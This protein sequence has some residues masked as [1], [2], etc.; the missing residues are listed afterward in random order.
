MQIEVIRFSL[1]EGVDAAEFA[2]VNDRY[3]E[4][5]AYQSAGLA[6]RTVAR[7]DAGRWIDIR[8][9]SDASSCD[10]GGDAEVRRR[11]DASVEVESREIYKGL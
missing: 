2:R 8:L 6:R 4:D 7:D 10:V 3:Q 1:A 9:W 11:W 5:V